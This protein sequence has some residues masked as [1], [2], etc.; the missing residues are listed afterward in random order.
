MTRF[1]LRYAHQNIL[2]GHGDA[3]AAVFRV[4]TVSYPFL[5]AADKREWL[6]RLA[7]FAFSVEADVS[8]YRV[9]RAYPAERYT[10]QAEQLLDAR[11]RSPAA[12]RSYLHA[13]EA[14]LRQLRSFVPE[15][16]LA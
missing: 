1:P 7:R 2:V 10:E 15:V 5:A 12:W 6:R 9:C 3:R 14:H 4:D 11:G 16:S 8:L 13:H